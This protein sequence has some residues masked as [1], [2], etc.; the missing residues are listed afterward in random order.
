MPKM[1]SAKSFKLVLL[2]I[3]YN[4]DNKAKNYKNEYMLKQ[5]SDEWLGKVNIEI[6]NL[7]NDTNIDLK[8]KF[9]VD[10]DG[11]VSV[12]EAEQFASKLFQTISIEQT[13]NVTSLI[14]QKDL[15]HLE[16][17]ELK[18]LYLEL[19]YIVKEELKVALIAQMN[20]VE[21][22]TINII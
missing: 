6:F 19:L 1:E 10:L 11:N 13:I 17:G 8:K 15:Q 20:Q 7:L 22:K 3:Y 21:S 4:I 14:K 18:K 5:A 2:Y 16:L 9:D 12:Q